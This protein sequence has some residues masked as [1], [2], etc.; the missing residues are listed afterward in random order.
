MDRQSETAGGLLSGEAPERTLAEACLA[1]GAL[2]SAI[3][4][5]DSNPMRGTG[6]S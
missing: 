3:L 1:G 4:G 6:A 5:P 2:A